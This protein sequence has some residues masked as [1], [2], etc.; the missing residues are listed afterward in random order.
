MTLEIL[1]LDKLILLAVLIFQL[2]EALTE[3][4]LR[5]Q[6][7]DRAISECLIASTVVRAAIQ[8]RMIECRGK[9]VVARHEGH[10]GEIVVSEGVN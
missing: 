1:Y 8:E 7:T 6:S 2:L 10:L 4:G 9:R 5:H 3:R